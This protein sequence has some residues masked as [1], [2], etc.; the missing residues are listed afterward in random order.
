MR[1]L[2]VDDS[3]AM[4][5][6]V[7]RIVVQAGY[8]SATFELADSGDVALQIIRSQKPELVLLDWHMPGMSGLDVL[9]VIREEQLSVCV[10]LVTTERSSQ[11]IDAARKAGAKFVIHKPFTVEQLKETLVPVLAGI[12]PMDEERLLVMPTRTGIE[13]T[14]AALC[15]TLVRVIDDKPAPLDP[16]LT[17]FMLALL[18][19]GKDKMRAIVLLDQNLICALGGAFGGL[20][21]AAVIQAINSNSVPEQIKGFTER[22]LRV[23]SGSFYDPSTGGDLT[24][25]SVH[26][27]DAN[28]SKLKSLYEKSSVGRADLLVDI[29]SYGGGRMIFYAERK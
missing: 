25:K 22:I 15:N 19:N 6:I 10:G 1:V 3:R 27:I 24:L 5:T 11:K 13:K 16:N 29:K 7:K 21:S 12:D 8:D 17:P 9:E 4:Q 18:N 23:L 2:I 20:S 26:M 28:F 14:L